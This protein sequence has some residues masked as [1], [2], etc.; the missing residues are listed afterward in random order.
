MNLSLPLIV[1]RLPNYI[2]LDGIVVAGAESPKVDVA[3]IPDEAL[4]A[5]ADEW[6][7]RLLKHAK[8]RRQTAAH[9]RD[10]EGSK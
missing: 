3:D 6:K 4:I 5:L 8:E 10:T 2:L 7:A 9:M 1:P